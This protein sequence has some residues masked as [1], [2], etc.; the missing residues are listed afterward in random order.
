MHRVTAPLVV[1]GEFQVEVTWSCGSHSLAQLSS[2]DLN[3]FT[4][5]FDTMSV[6]LR[7]RT[8]FAGVAKRSVR[9]TSTYK[10]EIDVSHI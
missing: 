3:S 6:L 2:R 1:A 7:N 10:A 8:L 4:Y 9:F 5:F